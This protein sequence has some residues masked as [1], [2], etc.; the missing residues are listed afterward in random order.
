M[1]A[2]LQRKSIAWGTGESLG[3][4]TIVVSA[5]DDFEVAQVIK[6]LIRDT[7]DF[8]IPTSA[9]V[10][11]AIVRAAEHTPLAELP[12]T[13]R[14]VVVV[15]FTAAQSSSCHLLFR[16]LR[17][18]AAHYD[19]NKMATGQLAVC[20]APTVLKSPT[21]NPAAEMRAMGFAITATKVMIESC[22]EIFAD[23]VPRAVRRK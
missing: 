5:I 18:M 17:T 3:P 23:V 4:G 10:Y 13:L 20:F 19:V 21:V 7:E 9:A 15:H 14:D 2:L 16:F 22:D 12:A 11:E 6:Q 1:D 8:L